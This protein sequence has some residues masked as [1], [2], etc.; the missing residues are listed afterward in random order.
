VF[1]RIWDWAGSI[2]TR[3]LNLGSD[4]A[5]IRMDLRAAEDDLVHL[6]GSCTPRE[7]AMIAHW[8]FVRV[9][10]FVDGNGRV[11]RLYADALLFALTGDQ[12]FDWVAGDAYY[13]ALRSADR[14]LSVAVLLD[15]VPPLML[16]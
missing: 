5:A 1:E 15:L 2:R 9:H 7:L 10:P 16:E 3:G 12:L 11:T 13:R 6:A 8:R 4:P 14:S